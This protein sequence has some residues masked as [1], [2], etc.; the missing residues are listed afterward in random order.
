MIKT[1]FLQESSFYTQKLNEQTIV[2]NIECDL[3]DQSYNSALS[4]L[5]KVIR[6]SRALF[7]DTSIINEIDQ[8]FLKNAAHKVLQNPVYHGEALNALSYPDQFYQRITVPRQW[9]SNEKYITLMQSL[10]S[11]VVLDYHDEENWSLCDLK[12]CLFTG[13][14]IDELLEKVAPKPQEK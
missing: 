2:P 9:L 6:R 5:I 12:S 3:F 13:K 1:E 7:G 8:S 11:K 14:T 4:T 10:M